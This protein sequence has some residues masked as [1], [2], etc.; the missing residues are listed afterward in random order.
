MQVDIN[1]LKGCIAASGMSQAQVAEK[2]GVDN[3][4]FIRKMKNNGLTFSVGQIHKIVDVLSMSP[5]E[6][7]RI[8]LF[9]NSQ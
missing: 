3:S 4:T 7:S 2:I 1:R 8:F 5:A 9:E 6:A